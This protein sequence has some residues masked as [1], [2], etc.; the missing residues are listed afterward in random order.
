M[1]WSVLQ[2]SSV[3]IRS[4]M[5]LQPENAAECHVLR[6]ISHPFK[7]DFILTDSSNFADDEVRIISVGVNCTRPWKQI[8]KLQKY[9]QIAMNQ[10]INHGDN[11]QALL[12][13][14]FRS[15]RHV[16]SSRVLRA[17]PMKHHTP[18]SLASWPVYALNLALILDA[19]TVAPSCRD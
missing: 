12:L 8:G 10:P 13:N 15:R 14:L 5:S 17:S 19:W 9:A 7:R 11:V 18:A 16:F 1:K 6:E 3:D 4:M 2:M